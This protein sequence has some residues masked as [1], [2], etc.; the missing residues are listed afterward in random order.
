MVNKSTLAQSPNDSI[1]DKR[2]D[3]YRDKEQYDE[4]RDVDRLEA[5]YRLR[6]VAIG[7]KD[8]HS[9]FIQGN[10][11]QVASEYSTTVRKE[12]RNHDKSPDNGQTS[13]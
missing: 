1:E 6:R 3:P 7:R 4:N 2:A 13:Q 12:E 5:D 11:E 9:R 8:A 10:R